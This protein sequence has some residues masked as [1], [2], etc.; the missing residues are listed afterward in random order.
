MTRSTLVLSLVAVALG[1]C[2]P[3]QFNGAVAGNP[4]VV[5]DSVLYAQRDS[6]GAILSAVVWLSD[7]PNLC[8]S[9][10]ANRELKSQTRALLQLYSYNDSQQRL[11]PGPAT[12]TVL[13]GNPP[14]SGN[15]GAAYFDKTDSTCTQTLANSVGHAKS[16]LVKVL[17]LSLTAS[18]RA[19]GSFDLTFGTDNVT[20]T[21]DAPFCD[22]PSTVDLSCQ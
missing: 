11:T 12:F 7:K 22:V 5:V 8:D 16:G 19:V 18:S 14:T 15:F 3:N 10:R 20:G 2:S 17:A 1:A 13:D 6:S 4:L 9:L 21:F